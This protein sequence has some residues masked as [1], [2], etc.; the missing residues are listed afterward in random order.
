MLTVAEGLTCG[1]VSAY[2]L[3]DD[4]FSWE[5]V[6]RGA[7]QGKRGLMLRTQYGSRTS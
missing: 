3:G 1:N 6:R 7:E 5:N 4:R 2:L